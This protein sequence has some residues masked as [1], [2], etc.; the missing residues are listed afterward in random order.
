MQNTVLQ[1]NLI[2]ALDNVML[3]AEEIV[4]NDTAMTQLNMHLLKSDVRNLYKIIC[5]IEL[6][7]FSPAECSHQQTVGILRQELEELKTEKEMLLRS[8]DCADDTGISS[9]KKDIAAM[10]SA[11][12]KLEA[13][14]AKYSAE[15]DAALKEYS[16]LKK[17]A[18]EFDAGELMEA[19]LSI[20]GEKERSAVTRVQDTYGEK[21][22][23]LM[24][25]DSKRDVA[26][27]LHEEA[28]TR[29][30][31]ER[32]RQKQQTKTQR[33]RKPKHY[34]QER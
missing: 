19:R 33:Q 11:L 28:E 1:N 14:E 34:E 31:R 10:E 7:E 20:R 5:Q 25:F 3:R 22:D 16:E 13:Q 4:T 12:K 27:L 17:Q 24:M 29:S 6:A 21:Y 15:L 2:D 18:S 9:I 26:N 8:L 23:S 32:L 30:V